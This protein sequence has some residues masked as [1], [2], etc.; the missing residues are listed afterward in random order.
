[1]L[2]TLA[3]LLFPLALLAQDSPLPSDPVFAA[4]GLD[5]SKVRGRLKGLDPAAGKVT[6][7][8]ESGEEKTYNWSEL[9]KLAREGLAYNGEPAPAYPPSGTLLLFPDGDRLAGTIESADDRDF[10]VRSFILDEL[11]VPLTAP[12][13]VILQA[14]PPSPGLLATLEGLAA[15]TEGTDLAKLL[16][17][18][19]QR[20][21]FLGLDGTNQKIRWR[22]ANGELDLD[23]LGVRA[24]AFDPGLAQYPRP[25]GPFLE[26]T[27][28]DGSRLGI[29]EPSLQ[30]GAIAGKT[31]FGTNI[32]LELADL[33][34]ATFRSD[35]VV[36]L[37]DRQPLL[38]EALPYA[39][40]KRWL[41]YRVDAAA[42]GAP[43]TLAG[44]TYDRGLG[45][46]SRRVVQFELLPGDRRFQALVGVD[47]RAGPSGGAVFRVLVD[48]EAKFRSEPMAA[49]DPPVALDI[50]VSEGKRLTLIVESGPRGEVRDLADWAEPRIIR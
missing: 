28:A 10:K 34:V 23:R 47:D 7:A 27:L 46:D 26:L 36:N 32:R 5:N 29:V 50:D 13:A 31:R 12:R 17:G 9:F 42:D 39:I 49:G 21:G 16:N 24:I 37:T 19:E 45:M 43:L 6:L 35:A 2:A 44:Q 15:G 25:K 40:D 8:L 14:Q 1:M 41:R 33:A 30:Q 20:G 48:R 3:P 4:T 18:D 22:A 38:N 11:A